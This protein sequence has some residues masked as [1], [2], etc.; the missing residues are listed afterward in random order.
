MTNKI[1]LFHQNKIGYLQISYIA[2]IFLSCKL[3]IKNMLK[4]LKYIIYINLSIHFE[5]LFLKFTILMR[6]TLKNLKDISKFL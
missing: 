6:A 5:F 1:I 2:N 4:M 3:T